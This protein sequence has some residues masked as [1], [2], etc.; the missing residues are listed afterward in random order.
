MQL[1]SNCKHIP[2]HFCPF[3][4]ANLLIQEDERSDW[5]RLDP[6][7]LR[8]TLKKAAPVMF[9]GLLFEVSRDVRTNEA[10]FILKSNRNCEGA[11]CLGI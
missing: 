2:F 1:D 3:H 7:N 6:S 4:S 5:V 11:G 8:P 10:L 9:S